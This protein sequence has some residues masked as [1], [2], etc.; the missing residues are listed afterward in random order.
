MLEV[1]TKVNGDVV[2]SEHELIVIREF[3]LYNKGSYIRLGLT[4]VAMNRRVSSC[5]LSRRLTNYRDITLSLKFSQEKREC[6][7]QLAL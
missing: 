2:G 6:L 7:M 5:I 4:G 3:P 1:Q